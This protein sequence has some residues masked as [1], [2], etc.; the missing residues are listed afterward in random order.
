[1]THR[2]L[3][4]EDEPNY[5]TVLS[6]MLADRDVE[7]LEAGDG[8]AALDLLSTREVDLVITDVNMPRMDGL[9]LLAKL[10]ERTHAPPVIV[11]TAY[12]TVDVAVRAMRSGAID[13]L[14]KPFDEARLKLTLDRAL[15]LTSLMSENARLRSALEE[16]FDFSQIVGSSPPLLAALETAGKA[17]KSEAPILVRGESGTGKELVARAI[18]FT[19]RDD[20]A[21]SS[22]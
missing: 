16:R 14:E 22:P 8:V 9:T 18:H 7:I 5:R 12:G 13:F 1:V 11:V 15:A 3:H 21:R 2:I 10:A 17:A 6:L 4:V 19:R 20:T